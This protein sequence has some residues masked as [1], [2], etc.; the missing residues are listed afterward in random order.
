MILIHYTDL[1]G[2]FLNQKKK[3]YLEDPVDSNGTWC[4]LALRDSN[5]AQQ[6]S[7][8]KYPHCSTK[9]MLSKEQTVEL[10]LIYLHVAVMTD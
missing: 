8:S 9:E 10:S 3:K 5:R 1:F 7:R 2:A 6:G 4:N